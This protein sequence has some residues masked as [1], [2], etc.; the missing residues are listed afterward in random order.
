MFKNY[1]LLALRNI[2]KNKLH[3]SINMLGMCVAFACSIIILLMVYHHFSF[4]NFQVNKSQLYKVYTHALGPN[5]EENSTAMPYALTPALEKEDIGIRLSTNILN[6]G[7]LVRYKDKTFDMK[8]TLVDTD[9]L[10]MFSFP[11]VQG[12]AQNPLSSTNNVVL[13]EL[14]AKKIFGKEDPIGKSIEVKLDGNW[15]KLD[16]TAV[17]KDVPDNSTIKFSLLARTEIY[18]QYVEMRNTWDSRN[19]SVYVQLAENTTAQQVQNR[20]RSFL[21]KYNPTD[22]AIAKR[23]GYKPDYNG[24]YFS[25]RLLPFTREHFTPEMSESGGLP[26]TILYVLMLIS[27]LIILIASFNFININIG[28]SF[29][30]T[31]EI[32][33]RKCLG[34]GKRQIW[35]QV[36]GESFLMVLVSMMI[37]LGVVAV[38]IKRFNQSFNSKLSMESLMHPVILTVLIALVLLVSFIAS[39]YPSSVMSRLKT[40]EILKGKLT[41]RRPGILRSTLIVAQFVIA[42]VLL[43]STVIIF[44]QFDYLRSAPLGYNTQSVISIPIK[45][46]D[47]GKEIV[48]RLR[49]RLSSQSSV[50]AVS[51][52][53]VNLGMGEDN[54]SST[55]LT[56][57]TY[58]DKTIC[59][60]TVE[61]GYDI[62][63]TL[64]IQLMDGRDFSLGNMADTGM[65][66]I[67]TK[68][69]ADQ[70]GEKNMIGFSYLPDSSGPRITVVGV[71]PDIQI[72]ALNDRQRPVVIFLNRSDRLNYAFVKVNT[73]NPVAT[74]NM[75][76]KVYAG[77]EPGIE[78]KGSYVNENIDRLYQDENMMAKLFTIAAFITIILSCMGLFGLAS[79]IIR[80]RVK[81]IGVRKVLGA[82][83]KNIF[84]LVSREFLKPVVI[85]F[86]IAVPLCWWAMNTWLQ[87]YAHRVNIHWWV[88][89]VA[90]ILALAITICTVGYQSIKAAMANPV[91]SLRTE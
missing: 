55:S 87:N 5:G 58:K 52:S 27:A 23:D 61:A 89:A 18:P 85:A 32:G 14:S 60:Q 65:Q 77:I 38:L 33:I 84:A 70:F 53:D 4:D 76:K 31:K 91:E 44:Q 43:C 15:Y 80:Q 49:T 36:W 13:S 90:G 47:Q 12:D 88:F 41:I 20:L 66:I 57:F 59:G 62:L 24:D 67:A 6:T 21:K 71:I 69:Y 10:K 8:S 37:S 17:V 26:K 35:M 86:L 68:S 82:S 19:H 28:L 72:K 54:R 56:C 25:L 16:V 3:A 75:I 50:V 34:A 1:F 83:V 48:S 81:E 73:S 40:V 30:R 74:M 78:F 79:I 39:G 42:I 9:F 22:V 7:R 63:K 11:V 64:G 45:D 2:R 29:T 46:N 51:G